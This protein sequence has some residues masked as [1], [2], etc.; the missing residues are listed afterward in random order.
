[1]AVIAP[2]EI[3]NDKIPSSAE[4][5]LLTSLNRENRINGCIIDGPLALD[6]AVSKY[7]SEC[8]GIKSEV[9][10]DA[11]VL[12]MHDLNSGNI[13]YKSLI[14]LSDGVS[15]AIITGAAAPIVLT[16]RADSEKS[17]LFSIALAASLD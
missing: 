13:L 17:K 12:V 11:D 7:A 2:T 16:S 14:F 1:V 9:A 6:A 15:A 5:A 10:G 3:V 8:K 4:A